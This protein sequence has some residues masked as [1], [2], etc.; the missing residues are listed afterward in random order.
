MSPQAVE[1]CFSKLHLPFR[2]SPEE[3][4]TLY[5]N[6]VI[7]MSPDILVF[8]TPVDNQGLN[9]LNVRSVV[10]VDPE[11]PPSFFDHPWYLTESFGLADCEPGWHALHMEASRESLERPYDYSDSLKKQGL[12]LPSAVEVILM[13]FFRFLQTGEHLL[14]K[15]HTW[16]RDQ[17]TL[18][19][20]VTV[21]AF[22]R[23]GVFVSGHPPTFASRGLGICGKVIDPLIDGPSH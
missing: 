4:R 2:F 22:G 9:L 19:R 18:G 23:N 21:G 15:K 1:E 7:G 11:A 8:P 17:A 20:A 12:G 14:L 16:C 6:N 3:Q 5:T 13:L 10:G